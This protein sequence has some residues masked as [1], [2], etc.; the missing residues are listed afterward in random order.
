MA[1]EIWLIRHGATAWSVTGQHTGR[2][3]LPLTEE[4]EREA[5]QL[6]P[7]LAGERFDAVLC[8]PLRRALRTCE[9][10]GF[11]SQ[12]RREPDCMEWDYGELN[13]LTRDA[14]R[15]RHP[16]WTI[17][18]GPVP[19]GESLAEVA[20]RAARVLGGLAALDGRA[21]IF[22]H[23]HFLRIL[24]AVYLGLDPASARH[25]ALTTARVSV[26]GRD[27]GEAAILAWNR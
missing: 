17:W 12:A 21:A 18:Q 13:G 24:T 8:S 9:I 27:N 3:D 7:K 14:Y 4:G 1:D 25:F 2:T 26:L 22:A 23:G 16:G 15:E 19:G 11:A 5:A 6:I 10:C 20:R